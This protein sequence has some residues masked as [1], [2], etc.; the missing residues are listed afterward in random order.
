MKLTVTRTKFLEDRTLGTLTCG[1]LLVYTLE[2]QV[3]VD[4]VMATPENEAKVPGRTAIPPGLY[5]LIIDFSPRFK[6][7]LP[8]ILDVPGFTGVR[9][10]P[11]NVPADTEGCIL[12]G[13][14]VAQDYTLRSSRL[15]FD[16]LFEL[17]EQA[18]DEGKDLSIEVI[19]GEDDEPR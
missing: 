7:E 9:I 16:E 14:S 10:H 5:D 19:N 6:R 11:G 8:H 3:R 18:Y 2:D 1:D 12:V 13:K 17:L 4:P 15:A